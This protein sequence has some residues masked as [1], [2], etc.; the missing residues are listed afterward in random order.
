MLIYVLRWRPSWISDRH[1][2]QSLGKGHSNDH[3]FTV[4]RNDHWKVLYKVSVF[5]ADRKSKMVATAEH[6][7]TLDPMGKCSNAFFS[8]TTNMIKVKL[9]MNVQWQFYY[10]LQAN[11]RI[12]EFLFL[13]RNLW[14]HLA[15]FTWLKIMIPIKNSINDNDIFFIV[16][17]DMYSKRQILVTCENQFSIIYWFLL[18][19]TVII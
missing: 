5:Y 18:W 3:S 1:K 14:S 7:L 15:W 4:W 9:Y 11:Q 8:E 12:I 17:I 10:M 16:M 2:K 19:Y 6:R 13:M